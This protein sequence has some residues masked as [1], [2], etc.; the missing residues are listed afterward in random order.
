MTNPETTTESANETSA[1]R[2]IAAPKPTLMAGMRS[3]VANWWKPEPTNFENK[4]SNELAEARTDLAATRTLMAADRTLMAWVRTALSLI[5]FGFTI[6]KVLQGFQEK[7][8][9]LPHDYSPQT[10]GLFLTGLG[11]VSMIMGVIEYR[12][13]VK[14]LRKIHHVPTWRSSIVMAM[15]MAATGVFFFVSIVTKLL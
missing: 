4:S 10:V 3:A 7:G 8:A 15:I 1:Q 11:T 2:T 5:S 12:S 9:D 6:Y 14:E 13:N